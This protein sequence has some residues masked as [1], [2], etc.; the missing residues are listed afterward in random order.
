MV[1]ANALIAAA[2][3][4]LLAA[5]DNKGGGQQTSAAGDPVAK[6]RQDPAA[7][8]RGKAIFVGTCGAYCHKMTD[9][10]SDAPNLFDCTWLHGGSDQEIFNTISHGVPTTRMVPF[11]GAL[12]DDDIWKIV[13]YL[14]SES[15]CAK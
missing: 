1:K 10:Q 5:C 3:L 8:E 2:A 12:P 11:S 14:K 7:I 6:L 13:A 15:K 4:L 9:A